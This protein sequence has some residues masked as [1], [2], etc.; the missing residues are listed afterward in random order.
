MLHVKGD[1]NLTSYI[2][3][4]TVPMMGPLKILM[5]VEPPKDFIINITELSV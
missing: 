1:N 5:R 3:D 2:V 4:N